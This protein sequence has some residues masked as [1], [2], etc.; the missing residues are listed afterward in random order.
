M[1][2]EGV[3]CYCSGRDG[4]FGENGGDLKLSR[5]ESKIS[6]F[7]VLLNPFSNKKLD[8]SELKESADDDFIFDENGRIPQKRRKHCGKRRNF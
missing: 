5:Q 3:F 1:Q 7:G 2:N 8:S 4:G 6:V